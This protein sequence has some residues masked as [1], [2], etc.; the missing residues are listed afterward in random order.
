MRTML[1]LNWLKER[2]YDV[3]L[4]NTSINF[5]NNRKRAI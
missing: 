1:D 3:L 2:V 4:K 5:L